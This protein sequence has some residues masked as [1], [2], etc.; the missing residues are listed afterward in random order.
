MVGGSEGFRD[1]RWQQS[2]HN[3]GLQGMAC[4]VLRD[5]LRLDVASGP[6]ELCLSTADGTIPTF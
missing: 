6:L 5:N 1:G 3:V 2:I 4:H